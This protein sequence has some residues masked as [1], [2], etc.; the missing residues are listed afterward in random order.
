ML[1]AVITAFSSFVNQNFETQKTFKFLNSD[2][3]FSTEFCEKAISEANW[4]GFRFENKRNI[5]Q[6]ESGLKVELF[7]ATEI[8]ETNSNCFLTDY[9]D[10]SNDIWKFTENGKIVHLINKEVSKEQPT[11]IPKSNSEKRK[12]SIK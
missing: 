9:R 5:I 4:C 6:F 1:C 10:F 11:S 12:I 7:S 2:T 8:G 3:K